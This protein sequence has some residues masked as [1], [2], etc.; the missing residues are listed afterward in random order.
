MRQF[1]RI[2]AIAIC[3]VF[4][5]NLASAQ[6]VVVKSPVPGTTMVAFDHLD[7]EFKASLADANAGSGYRMI[8][9]GN[10]FNIPTVNLIPTGQG[11][12]VAFPALTPGEHTLTISAYNVAGEAV[13]NEL[14]RVRLVVAPGKPNNIRITVAP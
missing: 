9:D 3:G 7:A 1:A 2:A 13:S 10:P 14:L 5:A 4:L 8:V 6:T 12:S 11:F